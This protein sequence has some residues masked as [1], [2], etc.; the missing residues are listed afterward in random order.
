MQRNY[1]SQNNFPKNKVREFTTVIK[2][3]ILTT[4]RNK[5][6]QN[7]T[8]STKIE[9]HTYADWFFEDTKVVHEK[10]I[11]YSTNGTNGYAIC[12]I[13]MGGGS[14][15]AALTYPMYQNSLKINHTHNIQPNS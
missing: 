12:T 11:V 4:G 15:S 1:S 13:Q 5:E 7:K 3:A 14:E 2:T 9:P 8:E 6:Q 10:R